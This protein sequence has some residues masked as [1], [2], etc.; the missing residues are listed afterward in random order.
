MEITLLTLLM[1]N[2]SLIINFVYISRLKLAFF[3][4]M[5]S[6]LKLKLFL[7]RKIKLYFLFLIFGRFPAKLGPETPLNGSGLKNGAE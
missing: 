7:I 1:V 3:N 2:S 4:I 5:Y 6:E